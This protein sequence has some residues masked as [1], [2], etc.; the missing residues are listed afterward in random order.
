VATEVRCI[1]PTAKPSGTGCQECLAAGTWWFHLRRC[2]ECGH[3]GA[4]IA[5]ST[6]MQ[7]S[8]S[9]LP[10][11]QSSEVSSRVR[12]GSGTSRLAL[13]LGAKRL[14]RPNLIRKTSRCPVRLDAFPKI[15][16]R[17]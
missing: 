1:E 8:I 10:G 2:A 3:I 6:S 16:G 9:L 5:L 12:H 17:C 11:I 13:K 14:R 7:P 4:A 15:G